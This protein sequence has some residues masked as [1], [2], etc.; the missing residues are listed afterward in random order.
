M[1]LFF[2]YWCMLYSEQTLS[3]KL[4]KEESIVIRVDSSFTTLQ[5]EVDKQ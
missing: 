5:N 4:I 3:F 2:L 1:N